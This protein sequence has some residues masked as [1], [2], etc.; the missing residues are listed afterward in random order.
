MI[1]QAKPAAEKAE[2]NG[3]P[4]NPVR[5]TVDEAPEQATEKAG[6]QWIPPAPTD[7]HVYDDGRCRHEPDYPAAKDPIPA[8]AQSSRDIESELR[9]A[10][11]QGCPS[12]GK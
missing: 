4:L 12:C 8:S 5:L 9:A 10:F 7:G 6:S 1:A 2:S 3:V 11:P